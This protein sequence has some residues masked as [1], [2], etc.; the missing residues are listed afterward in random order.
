MPEAPLISVIVP[1]LNGAAYLAAAI[2]SIMGQDYRPLQVIVVDDGSTDNTA[3][4]AQAFAEVEYHF[5]DHAGVV[6]A[7]N[8]GVAEAEGSFIAFLDADD[9]WMEGKLR[10]QL[11]AFESDPELGM[12]LGQVEQFRET[13]P[14]GTPVS[15]GVFNGYLKITMLIRR[16]AFFQVGLFD[17]QWQTGDFIDWYIRAT[18]Q[19]LKSIMLP[20]ILARRRIHDT[21]MGVRER[22]KQSDYARIMRQVLERRRKA[23]G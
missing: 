19:R 6:T 15:L 20:D 13:G 1:V 22:D 4:V 9:L 10:R 8:K 16:D 21:N 11:Q 2:E 5:Q 12:V 17:S 3:A 18:E 14:D 23:K 7:L